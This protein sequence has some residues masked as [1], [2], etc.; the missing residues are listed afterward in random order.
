MQQAV[1]DP[2]T[3]NYFNL[4]VIVATKEKQKR[5]KYY[6]KAIELQPDYGDAY[7]NLAVL[8]L[9]EE[10]AIIDE[11]NE[12]LSILISMKNYKKSKKAFTKRPYLIWKM[13]INTGEVL[14]LSKH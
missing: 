6:L 10:K 8:I 11:M 14:I 9:D 3:Q 7:M 13:L 4:G 1:E 12:N 5:L 2:Q